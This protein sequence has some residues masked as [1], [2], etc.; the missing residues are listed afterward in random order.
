MSTHSSTAH[1]TTSPSSS[2]RCSS[3]DT[4]RKWVGIHGSRVSPGRPVTRCCSI[5]RSLDQL[6]AMAMAD[7]S[8]DRHTL[9]AADSQSHRSG[10]G[11]V[12]YV[13]P[14]NDSAAATVATRTVGTLCL[15]SRHAAERRHFYGMA[16]YGRTVRTT[17]T[18]VRRAMS[19]ARQD[20]RRG[21][22]GPWTVRAP[23]MGKVPTVAGS[24]STTTGGDAVSDMRPV[25]MGNKRFTVHTVLHIEVRRQ[26]SKHAVQHSSTVEIPRFAYL[27]KLRSH[28]SNGRGAVKSIPNRDRYWRSLKSPNPDSS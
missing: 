14:R 19:R 22:V 8:I 21:R 25:R 2:A 5:D 23:S 28:I 3:M 9:H 12:G 11:K 24:V 13:G 1:G 15:H 10:E 7:R 27:V 20:R 6:G 17:T 26:T 16:L 18:V 4:L